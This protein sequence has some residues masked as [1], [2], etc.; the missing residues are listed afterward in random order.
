MTEPKFTT[1]CRAFHVPPSHT[2]PHAADGFRGLLETYTPVLSTR[3]CLH[4]LP[5]KLMGGAV[6]AYEDWPLLVVL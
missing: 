4:L 5:Q 6:Q 2:D 3:G 1:E